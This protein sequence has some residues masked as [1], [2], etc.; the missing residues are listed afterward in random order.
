M[1]P[2]KR[3]LSY[4]RRA[5]EDYEMIR[6]NDRVAVGI[7]GGKDSLTLL[8]ALAQLRRFYPVPFEVVAISVD[9]PLLSRLDRSRN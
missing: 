8:C 7:S 5:L 6:P 3:I 1:E 4:T 2:I 9:V